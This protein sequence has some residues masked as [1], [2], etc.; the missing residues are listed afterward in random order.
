MSNEFVYLANRETRFYIPPNTKLYREQALALRKASLSNWEKTGTVA[1]NTASW[2]GR[3]A[4]SIPV[5]G[6][7]YSAKVLVAIA[8]GAA[9]SGP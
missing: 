4:I 7:V 9:A 3:S 2:I 5:Y 6:V 1:E 8:A